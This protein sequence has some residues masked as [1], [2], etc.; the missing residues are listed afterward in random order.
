MKISLRAAPPVFEAP[1]ASHLS[2]SRWLYTPNRAS[3]T[4]LVLK[5]LMARV[6][7]NEVTASPG[8]VARAAR[9]AA[10]LSVV[11]VQTQQSFEKPGRK[12]L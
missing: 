12:D 9:K 8:R 6:E 5:S 3:S 7:P 4:R 10:M 1:P 11:P 2:S